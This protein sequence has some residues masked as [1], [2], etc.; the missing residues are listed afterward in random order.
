MRIRGDIRVCKF[1]D[2]KF[3]H[4][5]SYNNNT[6]NNNNTVLHRSMNNQV[7]TIISFTRYSILFHPTKLDYHYY[8]F[9][10]L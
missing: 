8:N 4:R 3:S 7:T 6:N 2:E 5:N 9:N 1:F 10:D